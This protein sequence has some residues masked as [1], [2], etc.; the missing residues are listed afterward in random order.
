[1]RAIFTPDIA[2]SGIGIFLTSQRPLIDASVGIGAGLTGFAIFDGHGIAASVCASGAACLVTLGECPNQAAVI[3]FGALRFE[4]IIHKCICDFI[5]LLETF[6][7]EIAFDGAGFVTVEV[8]G[9][10]ICADVCPTVARVDMIAI[11][12][13]RRGTREEDVAIAEA[14]VRGELAGIAFRN[15]FGVRVKRRDTVAIE[16]AGLAGGFAVAGNAL[17]LNT[18]FGRIGAWVFFAARLMRGILATPVVT[19]LLVG[20]CVRHAACIIGE[21]FLIVTEEAG[22]AVIIL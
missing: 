3:R 6:T 12:A 2:F 17:S 7:I 10:R 15:V 18:C 14:P 5:I 19:D 22:A 1:M 13:H 21:T 4:C 8:F 11:F 16:V 9:R 20:A